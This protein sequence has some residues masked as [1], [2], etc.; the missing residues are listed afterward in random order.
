MWESPRRAEG[1]SDGFRKH[2]G[3]LAESLFTGY[4]SA[5]GHR[6]MARAELELARIVPEL[7][8][9]TDVAIEEWLIRRLGTKLKS[10]K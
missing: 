3:N 2:A 9:P 8:E 6:T 1:R 5:G 4:G 7:R 10:L